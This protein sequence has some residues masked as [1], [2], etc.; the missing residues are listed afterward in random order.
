MDMKRLAPWLTLVP[1]QAGRQHAVLSDGG[2]RIRI[3]VTPGRWTAERAMRL[4]FHF[5]SLASAEAG[6]LPMRRLILL[7]RHQ[8]FGRML[9]P[10][11]PALRRGIVLLRVHDALAAG[12]THRDIAISLLGHGNAD[13]DWNHPSDSL[14]SR[15]RRLT[16][17]ARAM[18]GGGFRRLM[19]GG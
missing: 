14:R 16:R 6:I 13:L 17:Q 18:A 8:R 7:Y 12:A 4:R 15:I 11:D 5:D 2:R 3:D 10:R 9:Y 19:G 1:G